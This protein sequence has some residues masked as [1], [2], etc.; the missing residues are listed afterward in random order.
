MTYEQFKQKLANPYWTPHPTS[1]YLRTWEGNVAQF[2]MYFV[3]RGRF[4]S[5]LIGDLAKNIDAWRLAGRIVL[6]PTNVGDVAD[7]VVCMTPA[8]FC[9]HMVMPNQILFARFL[10]ITTW[11]RI[12]NETQQ[13]SQPALLWPT[14]T[15]QR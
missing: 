5:H 2:N 10:P 4:S 15:K 8:E 11:H 6:Q 14:Q 9:T 12:L 1:R 7:S 13:D 3:L